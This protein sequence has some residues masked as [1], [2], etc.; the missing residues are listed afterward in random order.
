[1][2]RGHLLPAAGVCVHQIRVY[3]FNFHFVPL[4]LVTPPP[5]LHSL[6]GIQKFLKT[7]IKIQ[8]E[9]FQRILEDK[10]FLL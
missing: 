7:T 4:P 6:Y 3:P 2:A 5:H 10:M 8:S 9:T 1:M